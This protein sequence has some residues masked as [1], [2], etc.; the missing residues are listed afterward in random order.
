M[1]LP[2]T[3]QFTSDIFGGMGDDFC[4]RSLAPGTSQFS[5]DD[6]SLVF[7]CPCGCSR[8]WSVPIGTGPKQPNQWEWNGDRLLPTLKPSILV[9]GECGWH[10]FLTNGIFTRC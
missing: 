2:V 10:G 7:I 3:I 4:N 5:V 9:I 8:V 6:K 1:K